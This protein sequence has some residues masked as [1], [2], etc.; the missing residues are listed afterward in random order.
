[1]IFIALPRDGACLLWMYDSENDCRLRLRVATVQPSQPNTESQLIFLICFIFGVLCS[2]QKVVCVAQTV[3]LRSADQQMICESVLIEEMQR[4][5]AV[6]RREVC[7]T[8]SKKCW[9]GADSE[10]IIGGDGSTTANNFNRIAATFGGALR[11]AVGGY[12]VVRL[13]SARRRHAGVRY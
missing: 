2:G 7:R 3:K 10:L 6:W 13:T 12:F 11:G 5:R 1:M 4:R 8:A 9:R